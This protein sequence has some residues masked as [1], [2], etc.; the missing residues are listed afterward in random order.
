MQR[1][2]RR[3]DQL[4]RLHL[5][6]ID[7]DRSHLAIR[8]DI[9]LHTCRLVDLAS[10]IC[11]DLRQTPYILGRVECRLIAVPDRLAALESWDSRVVHERHVQLARLCS[12]VV[13]LVQHVRLEIVRRGRLAVKDVAGDAGQVA[14]DVVL[15]HDG[16]DAFDGCLGGTSN[17]GGHILAVE[18]LVVMSML[19]EK[20]VRLTTRSLYSLS[21]DKW[22]VVRPVS[23]EPISAVV[24]QHR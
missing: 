24:S 11:D 19:S 8:L 4:S 20:R 15:L 16:R 2:V 10:E 14:R 1:H 3:H 12:G 18:A 13:D 6:P 17:L 21:T 7:H 9:V 23:P 22:P 5:A